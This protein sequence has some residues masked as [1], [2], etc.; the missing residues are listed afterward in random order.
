MDLQKYIERKLNECSVEESM[1]VSALQWLQE[2]NFLVV[3]DAAA[4]NEW[5]HTE[6]SNWLEWARSREDLKIVT[7]DVPD[8]IL[9]K[10][11][12]GR[13]HDVKVFS[14]HGPDDELYDCQHDL[15]VNVARGN[16]FLELYRHGND[17]TVM[18]VIRGMKK[19][20]GGLGD[21]DD[22]TSGSDFIWQRYFIQPFD[23]AKAVVCT[24]KQNG[25]AAHLSTFRIGTELYICA[26]SKNVHL[27]FRSFSDLDM[28]P[29]HEP[30]YQ[31]AKEI[32]RCILEML[33]GLSESGRV[34]LLEFLCVTRSTAVFELLSPDHQHIEDLSDFATPVLKFI[35]W[36]SCRLES[37]DSN[38]AT[39]F[40]GLPPDSGIELARLFQLDA[41]DYHAISVVSLDEHMADIRSRY[42]VEGEVL[43]F[44]D[45]DRRTIGILKKKT[46]WYVVVRAIRQKVQAA[47]LSYSKNAKAF[48]HGTHVQKINQR[49]KEIQQ[50]LQLSD[51]CLLAWKRLADKFLAVS[52][53]K[54]R[55]EAF[56]ASDFPASFPVCWK[57]F[58]FES[59]ETDS[60]SCRDELYC[61]AALQQ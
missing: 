44:L 31:F 45:G 15:R 58:L 39:Q 17:S 46:V 35:A 26:G 36:T 53:E 19:F 5:L 42:G 20:T 41:T 3:N 61:E 6:D 48:F 27:V 14:Q 38:S 22:R 52:I 54:L 59:G 51:K 7:V 29:L 57:R 12:T 47:C 21:D 1:R 49:L 2:N 60:I 40:C 32:S 33:D 18:C 34:Y 56:T 55:A 11:T 43:F 28:Y 30:R 10:G 37:G 23:T 24:K 13:L 16:C 25:E 50:W 8:G 9:P 4:K